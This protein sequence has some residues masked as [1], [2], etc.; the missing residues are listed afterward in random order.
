MIH[1]SL[2]YIEDFDDYRMYRFGKSNE[3]LNQPNCVFPPPEAI[4]KKVYEEGQKNLNPDE[5]LTRFNLYQPKDFKERS[6]SVSDVIRYYLPNDQ[7]LSLFCNGNGYIAVDFRP[8]YQMAKEPEYTPAS[9]KHGELVTHFYKQGDKM[10]TVTA[11]FNCIFPGRFRGINQDGN[12]VTLTPAEVYNSLRARVIGRHHIRQKEYIK[13]ITGWQDSYLPEFSDYVL[14]G[15]YVTQ[16]VVEHYLNILPPIRY[17][18]GYFQAGG[19]IC[20]CKNENG[21][22]RACYMTFIKPDDKWIY[23]GLCFEGKDENLVPVKSLFDEFSRLME[24]GGI[25]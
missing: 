8:E 24:L 10:R 16:T 11:D 15:D 14:P 20:D 13:S 2:H 3:I 6:V 4:Y 19:A 21:I 9:A 18:A 22:P 23:A 1:Y 5:V 17:H 25:L 7:S 12:T